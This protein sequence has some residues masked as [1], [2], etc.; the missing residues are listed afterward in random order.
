MCLVNYIF[1]TFLRKDLRQMRDETCITKMMMMMMMMTAII[2][3]V[4]GR[5]ECEHFS[6]SGMARLMWRV[7]Q[8]PYPMSKCMGDGDTQD[9]RL[10][11]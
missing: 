5:E 8:E 7:E 4:M 1:I 2:V 3:V 11:R 10:A 9:G 6:V